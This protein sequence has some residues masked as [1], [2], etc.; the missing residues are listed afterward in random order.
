[1][2]KLNKVNVV[3]LFVVFTYTSLSAQVKDSI[4]FGLLGQKCKSHLNGNL[5]S[6]SFYANK[7][8]IESKNFDNPRVKGFANNLKAVCFIYKGK[9]DSAIFYLKNAIHFYGNGS[10]KTVCDANSNLGICYDYLGNYS[11]AI[12]HYLRSMQIAEFNKDSVAI[13]RGG[14]NLGTIY[15]QQHDYKTAISYFLKSLEIR[16]RQKDDYGIASCCI[17]L[18]SCYDELKLNKESEM[19]FRRSLKHALIIGDSTLIAENYTAMGQLLSEAN[20]YNEA[21]E[22]YNKVLPIYHHLGDPRL[23]SEIYWRI[24]DTYGKLKQM[25]KSHQFLLMSKSYANS[26]SYLIGI[27]SACERLVVTSA[28][29]GNIDSTGYYL[30]QVNNIQ[31]TLYS[32]AN[33]KEIAAMTEKY[34]SDKK[35]AQIAL[36]NAQLEKQKVE[37]DKKATQRNV[38]FGALALSISLAFIFYRNFKSKSKANLEIQ[39]QKEVISEQNIILEEKQKEILDSIKYAKRIQMAQIPSENRVKNIIEKLHVKNE[40]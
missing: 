1:M 6:A 10:T 38:L 36:K 5:D 28:A 37:S 22:A 39:K 13:A 8:L 25:N 27:K 29:L 24:G 12:K 15:F 2:L 18:G 4:Y 30:Q 26:A 23:L 40:N 31:D 16:E 21:I 3:F 32:E 34:E 7:M 14:N 20:K 11:E 33:A 19:M 17:N 9:Y 35:D